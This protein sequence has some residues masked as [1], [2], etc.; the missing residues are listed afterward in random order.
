MFDRRIGDASVTAGASDKELES[1]RTLAEERLRQL[2]D[3][4]IIAT[5]LTAA[6]L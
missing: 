4:Q 1:L 2:P 3:E 6:D 5:D